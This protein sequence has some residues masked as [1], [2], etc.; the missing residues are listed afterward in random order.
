M[1]FKKTVTRAPSNSQ[2]VWEMNAGDVSFLSDQ[3]EYARADLQE[4]MIRFS[5]NKQDNPFIRAKFNCMVDK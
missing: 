5:T 3:T 4:K 2:G 1:I